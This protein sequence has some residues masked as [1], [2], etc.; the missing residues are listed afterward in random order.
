MLKDNFDI[1]A[2]NHKEFSEK[3]FWEIRKRHFGYE[4]RDIFPIEQDWKL[5]K[6]DET[7]KE[8]KNQWCFPDNFEKSEKGDQKET[9]RSWKN[10]NGKKSYFFE[11]R[12]V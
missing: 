5:A 4:K 7:K 12:R 11:K 3:Q 1:F 2:K 6:K 8:K 9:R 10:E